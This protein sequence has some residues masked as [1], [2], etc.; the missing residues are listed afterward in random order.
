MK[1]TEKQEK[2]LTEKLIRPMVR[3]MLK[4]E[5]EFDYP[6]KCDDFISTIYDMTVEFNNKNGKKLQPGKSEDIKKLMFTLEEYLDKFGNRI[7]KLRNK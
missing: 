1:L 7:N 2:L 5:T 6:N 4:E 3:K